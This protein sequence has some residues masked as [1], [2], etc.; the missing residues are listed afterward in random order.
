MN[1]AITKGSINHLRDCMQAVLD[2]LLG[3][4][5]FKSAEEH[6]NEALMQGLVKQEI[7]IAQNEEG[8]CIGFIWFTLDGAFYDFPYLHLV[9]VKKEFRGQGV[10]R[11]LLSFYEE[12]GFEKKSKIFLTVA[13]FNRRAKDLYTSLGYEEIGTLPDFL[14]EGISEHIMMK[15]RPK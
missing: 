13:D 14:K 3:D 15:T 4:Y 10:G 11:K 9:A 6:L 12:K 5:Y 1:I 8:Q 7:F 2:S